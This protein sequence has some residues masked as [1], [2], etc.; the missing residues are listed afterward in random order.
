MKGGNMYK[1][2]YLF[3]NTKLKGETWF[4]DTVNG[5]R[6]D[7]DDS[8]R[9]YDYANKLGEEGWELVSAPYTSDSYNNPKPRLIFKRQKP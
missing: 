1:W 9:M 6:L 3:V 8:L 7:S 5:K 2:E 4:A